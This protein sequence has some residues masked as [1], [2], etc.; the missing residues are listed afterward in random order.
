MKGEEEAHGHKLGPDDIMMLWR[1]KLSQVAVD[2]YREEKSLAVGECLPLKKKKQLKKAQTNLRHFGSRKL[3][4]QVKKD[5]LHAIGRSAVAVQRK[6]VLSN[7]EEKVR[8]K[9]SWQDHDWLQYVCALDLEEL[10]KLA[11]GADDWM[12]HLELFEIEYE[13]EVGLWIGLEQNQTTVTA[14]EMGQRQK[15]RKLSSK[16]PEDHDSIAQV[17]EE[18]GG[19]QTQTRGPEGKGEDKRR[20]TVLHRMFLQHTVQ[21]KDHR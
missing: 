4:C 13:D 20:I 15:R 19:G 6:S 5:L 2:L 11:S 10:K 3:R 7:A 16:N 12:K 9:L 14:E 17:Q 18:A 21:M 8:A 1:E